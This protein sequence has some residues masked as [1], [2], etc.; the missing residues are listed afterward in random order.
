VDRVRLEAR[1]KLFQNNCASS[2]D[3]SI[4][5]CVR[6]C[7]SILKW[8]F[9]ISVGWG[10]VGWLGLD[11]IDLAQDTDVWRAVVNAVMYFQFS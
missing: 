7:V 4:C 8:I 10:A 9:E 5:A 2:G 6:A 3:F 1:V 11:W